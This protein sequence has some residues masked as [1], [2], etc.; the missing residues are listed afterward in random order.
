MLPTVAKTTVWPT[1]KSLQLQGQLAMDSCLA[2]MDALSGP[3]FTGVLG[4]PIEKTE[5]LLTLAK[6]EVS[7]PKMHSFMTL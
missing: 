4:W 3:L 7:D 6:I 5:E 1:S 2:L